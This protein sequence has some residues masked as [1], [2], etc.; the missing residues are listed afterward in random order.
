MGE[1]FSDVNGFEN[2]VSG[3]FN[4]FGSISEMIDIDKEQLNK[5]FK[6]GANGL[7]E[8]TTAQIQAK[9]AAMG[10]QDT[11]TNELV[12]LGKDATFTQKAATGKLTWSNAVKD[13]KNDT[14]E[15]VD[16]LKR[17]GK[18]GE[19]DLTFLN[20][21]ENADQY[22]KR[23]ESIVETTDGLSDSI[24]ELDSQGKKTGTS[25]GTY[26][27]GFL[28]TI[29]PLLPAIA[30]ITVAMAA[31]AAI[32]Y[33]QHGFTRAVEEA[34][35]AASEYENV[36]SKLESL[37][38]ELETT[39]SRI[40]ELQALSD[41]GTITLAEEVELEKL[42]K[43]NDEIQRQI[44]LQEQLL[45]IKAEASAS[46]AKTASDTEQSYVEKM[47]EEH[48]AVLGTIIGYAGYLPARDA[49]TGNITN[50]AQEWASQDT[51]TIGQVSTNI[52]ALEE[53]KAE[54]KSIQ[55]QRIGAPDDEELISQQDEIQ[56]KIENTTTAIAD[57]ATQ[58][59]SW[60]DQSTDENGKALSGMEDYVDAWR[61]SLNEINNIGKSRKEID[62]NNLETFFSSSK[63]SAIGDYLEDVAKESDSAADALV[64]FKKLGL[65][66]NSID[67]SSEGFLKYFN[68]IIKS[69]NE[70]EEAIEK[71][72]N[73]ISIADIEGATE[74]KN[75]GDDYVALNDYIKQAKK[76][77]DQGLTGTDDF[78]IVA[79][80]LSYNLDS[81]SA[82]F[83]ENY[84]KLKSYFIEDGD[85]N[86]TAQGIHNFLTDLNSLNE[87]YASFDG[88]RWN[89]DI[90]NTAQAAKEMGMSV[91]VFEA[92]L[93]RIKDYD[94][95]G[96]FD[97][98]SAIA[99]FEE[100]KASLSGL[101]AIY[102][103]MEDSD[104]KVALKAKLDEWTPIVDAAENDL[105]S[106]PNELSTKLVFEYEAATLQQAIDEYTSQWE[107]GNKTVEVGANRNIAQEQ[108]RKTREEQT[109]Y[110]RDSSEVYAASYEKIDEIRKQIAATTDDDIIK[111]LQEQENAI[112]SV[113]NAFQD[114]LVDGKAVDWEAYLNSDEA[115]KIMD[116]LVSSGEVTKEDLND[117]FEDIVPIKTFKFDGELN[118]SNI[119]DALDE[120]KGNSVLTYEAEIKGE[121]FAEIKAY[122][123]LAGNI[124]YTAIID[125]AEKELTP[126]LTVDGSLIYE[127]STVDNT[128]TGVDSATENLNSVADTTEVAINVTSNAKT[129]VDES[130]TALSAIDGKVARNYIVTYKSTVGTGDLAGTAHK[131]GTLGGLYPI[132]KLSGRA[133]RMGTLTNDSWLKSHW[134]TKKGE[135]A[136]TGEQDQEMVVN[137]NR[138]WT[139]GDNGAE[140]SYIPAGSVVFNAQQTKQ[141]LSKGFINSR[142]KSYLGGTA[143][144][145][146]AGGGFPFSG[147]A[148]SYNAGAKTSSG[149]SSKNNAGTNSADDFKETLDEIEILL[150]RMERSFDNLTDSIETYSHNLSAQNSVTDQV[151]SMARSNLETLE[152][153][154]AR[155][156]QEA[157]NVDLSDS[158]KEA[159]RDGAIDITKITDE[160]LNENIKEYQ[161]WYEKSLDA[162]DK[163]LETQKELLDLAV[164]KIENIDTYYGNRIDYNDDFGYST[165]ISE[166]KE[167]VNQL[168]TELQ[169][170]VKNGVITQLSNEWYEAM[171]T[172][173]EREQELLEAT[174]KKYEDVIDHLSR[175]SDTLSDSLD[176]KEAQGQSLTES[177]YQSQIDINNQLIQEYYDA[178]KQYEKDQAILDF[179]TSGYDELADKIAD[180]KS[181]IFSLATANEE[182]EDAIWDVRFT[183]P[184]DE[185]IGDIDS[186]IESTDNLRNLLD[187]DAFFDKNGVITDDGLAAI[188][189]LNQSLN[190]SKQKVT[191]Y[192]EGLKILDEA[193][194]NGT[195]SEAKYKEEQAEMIDGL[196]SSVADVQGYK[197]ELI[198]LYKSQMK[199]EADYLTKIVD[200]YAEA[201]QKKAEYWDYNK[202]IKDQTKTVNMLKSEIS[203]L[204]GVNNASAQSELKRLRAELAEA[205]ES[206]AEEKRDHSL[207]MQD[208]GFDAMKDDINQILEDTE[209]E[210]THNAEKQQSV[211]ANMLNNVVQMYSDAYGKINQ[212]IYDTGFVG[213][214]S[215]TENIE[216]SG[217]NAGSQA[218]ADK[219]NLH[220]SLVTPSASVSG[221][222]T[223][224]VNANSGN[225]EIISNIS[226]KQDINNRPIAELK[227]STSSI[228]L[229][230][231]KSTAISTTIRPTDAANKTLLW[232][233]SNTSIA[234][235]SS[236]TIKAVSPGSCQVT[237]STTDGS[238]I[239]QSVAVTVTKKPEPVKQA[240]PST[241]ANTSTAGDGTPN[242][243]DAVTF[244]SGRYYYDSQGT[245]PAG[246]KYQGKQVYIT[247]INDKSWATKKYHISTGKT[248]GNGDL[249]WV[250][251]DQLKGYAT[252][253]KFIDK[254]QF[255][256]TQEKGDEII[257]RK[258]GG[259]LTYLN[260]GDKV[261]TNDETENM[262][263]WAKLNP[264]DYSLSNF[265]NPYI[266]LPNI[267]SSEPSIN[268]HY[269]TLLNVQGDV[270][271]NT[272]PELEELLKWSCEYTREAIRKDARK[273]GNRPGR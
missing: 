163:V 150:N 15:L 199:A 214:T 213:N 114:A 267:K 171:A 63:G 132:P 48:G 249:G 135:Y 66:L 195:I 224:S 160:A 21:S 31:L 26:F 76:L 71:V 168:R 27:K 188:S 185:L 113:M 82:S 1:L 64:A 263:E 36:K 79:E 67:V 46:A 156:L 266:I 123:D 162:Q 58:L 116:N 8:Y 205:E 207:D 218:Q 202:R 151:M 182:L 94:N 181:E 197:N 119:I 12:A 210:I 35:T 246:N 217:T 74:S 109:G 243:G 9:S 54:L 178:I 149:N 80:A 7:S 226:K 68:D 89:I 93:G 158:W 70:T 28:G 126:I 221:T 45:S 222:D 220:Q 55:E 49:F 91:E 235:V 240:T 209:Y 203:A 130:L 198:D 32:D 252:G 174:W 117:L 242:V 233:S 124:T 38:S 62:L 250:T 264:S 52:K 236:G 75:A 39:T 17:S 50:A 153:A 227:L 14:D 170:Q 273:H 13:A 53:Y 196:Q 136:L 20:Q 133:L 24:I 131:D 65:D 167:V 10:L 166:F 120:L 34:E 155:Y 134:K 43:E 92:L 41:A 2:L 139:V 77:F 148:S 88:N 159:V 145:G 244:E 169:N 111:D 259:I 157:N 118:I 90:K 33:S 60:I 99:E 215:S 95:I 16:A 251:L 104:K 164:Q 138:W 184:F 83:E 40:E 98:T 25:L 175:V 61:K 186:T 87:A 247:R 81:S 262:Y 146:E 144:L 121:G 51:T 86:L 4:R 201:K 225:N 271:K 194:E 23:L 208:A 152:A 69:A 85:E 269:D 3:E 6:I 100:A 270:S 140:F 96:D 239:S 142:G 211:I 223:S 191:E 245:A 258:D 73:T 57:Q 253:S 204:E 237:V 189:L 183:T 173:A 165:Q 228:T 161:T 193:Y 112:S 192:S 56:S 176:L 106:F 122:K 42:K 97:F 107:S 241:N 47:Q 11:L 18:I 256:W 261:L 216:S 154:S 272:L 5:A 255:A 268:L 30:G 219:G 110:T 180:A 232:V 234:T 78:K 59:Q 257:L 172:I 230:E 137:G 125:D 265:I 102:D 229:E 29:K 260:Q 206:L 179:G 22:R 254:D 72:D 103:E 187:E 127:V 147:G 129:V 212:I 101:Q 200:K 190:E 128:A 115:R 141:L 44:D 108:Y 105:A 143:Y 231:G 238:G 37:N 248:L 19:K 177:D 84:K